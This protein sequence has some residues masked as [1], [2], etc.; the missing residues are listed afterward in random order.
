MND[1]SA[2]YAYID[3][4]KDE[5]IAQ[6]QTMLHQPSIAA[7]GV[8]MIEMAAMVQADMDK[9]GFETRQYDTRGGFPVVYGEKAGASDK[10]LVFYDHYDV[11]PADPFDEWTSDPWSGEIRD[12]KI[13]AR[14]VADNKGNIAARFAA[15]DAWQRIN[16][17]LPL[18]L[19]FII[20]GEEEV[21]SMHLQNFI[22]DH[23]DLCQADACIWEFGGRDLDGRPQIHLGLKGICYVELRASGARTDWHSSMATSIPNPAWRLVWALS[24]LKD[25]NDRILIPGFYDKVVPPT[26]AELKALADLPDNEREL[27]DDARIPGFINGLTG[28]DLRLKD[29]FEPTCT[30]SGFLSGYTEKGQKTVLPSKAMAK[31]DMRLCAN[32]DPHEIY[33]LLRKYLDD[34]GFTDIESELIGAGYPAR[35]SL[36][37]PIAKV[38]AETYEEVFGESPAIYPTSSGSGPWYQLCDAFGIDAATAGVGHGRSQAHAPDENIY[39]D[40]FILG[41]KH[42][43]AI[44]DRF[45]AAEG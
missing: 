25:E 18:R 36:E 13:F 32:Q 31:I 21:G 41:I 28:M 19:K 39:V 8:G 43:V 1:L 23:N 30:I 33:A 26:E 20:E 15:I 14:G 42:I 3:E 16:G 24:T 40:D 27:L 37:A 38:V 34:N 22:D 7:Q 44:M 5:Y 17:E 29:Y 12:G 11:Q 35:T 6:L 45:A 9:L 2:V 10:T 4:H